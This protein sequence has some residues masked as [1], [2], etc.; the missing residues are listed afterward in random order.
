MESPSDPD[1]GEVDWELRWQVGDTP[2]ERGAA[3]PPLVDWLTRNQLFGQVLVPGCG[4]G[5]DVRELARAGAEP[6]GM[7]ISP[8]AINLAD[9]QPRVGPERYRLADLFELPPEMVGVFDWIFEH[10]CFCAIDPSRRSDYVAAARAAL[11]PTG[12]LLAIF[13]L[14]PESEVGP[15]FGVTREE[16]DAAFQDA[17]RTIDEY[18]PEVVFEGREGRELIRVL[19][20][21]D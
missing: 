14:T 12:R 20:R 19:E 8:Y 11:K 17:F 16:L 13:F 5:Q 9:S 7:D 4:S 21:I 6:I 15:P 10:T 2:W 18:V 1:G 3:A